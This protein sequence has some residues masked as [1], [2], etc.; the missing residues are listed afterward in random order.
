LGYNSNLLMKSKLLPLLLLFSCYAFAQD[1]SFQL[2]DYKY[3]TPGFKALQLSLNLSGNFVE[4]KQIGNEVFTSTNLQLTPSTL[5]FAKLIS[6]DKR[7]HQSSISWHPAFY[8][9][10]DDP[11]NEEHIYNNFQSNL[12]WERND[13]FY[14]NNLWFFE[15]GNSLQ[16]SFLQQKNRISSST[17]YKQDLLLKNT[18][19]FGIGKGRVEW[20]QDAQMALYI[21]NDL[22]AQSL[23]STEV[24]REHANEFAQLITDINNKRVFDFRKRRIYE[25]SRID[26]FLQSTGLVQKTDIRHFTTVNDNWSL[27]F[28]PFRLSG[29]NW[30]FRIKPGIGYS[31]NHDKQFSDVSIYRQEKNNLFLT[32]SPEL[33]YQKYIPASLKWQHNMGVSVSYLGTRNNED[34]R[35]VSPGN[36]I[37]TENNY[38]TSEWAVNGFYGIGFSPSNRTQ[39]TATANLEARYV[40][41]YSL[42]VSPSLNFNMD[43]FVSYRTFLSA[44]VYFENDYYKYTPAGT[45]EWKDHY[46][47]VGLSLRLSHAIF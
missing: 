14:K 1:S 32:I 3:R 6:T 7:L 4:S 41:S 16:N 34:I 39:V 13:R 9:S 22:A 29:A 38:N 28:N 11:N 18:S 10:S 30:Y 45:S 26:S 20:V 42:W 31:Q 5:S 15:I 35:Q 17:I 12:I 2:K 37:R 36:E 47:S 24:T 27:A 25:L 23:L 40:N 44:G 43:Y 33:G 46:T 8:F 21:L 19:T